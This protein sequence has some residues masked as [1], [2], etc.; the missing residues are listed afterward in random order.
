MTKIP[1]DPNLKSFL[2][3]YYLWNLIL[4]SLFIIGIPFLLL[5]VLGVG[6]WLTG[7]SY[8]NYECFYSDKFILVKKGI[9]FK[10]EKTIP[11]DK[12]QDFTI[13]RGPL[14]NAY[15]LTCIHI[16]TAGQGM[17]YNDSDA[18]LIGIKNPESLEDKILYLKKGI[19]VNEPLRERSETLEILKD[20]NR[21]LHKILESNKKN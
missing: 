5:W 15:G 9:W 18:S 21:T 4:A 11:L 16:E 3:T 20:I 13:R 6:K 10:T 19:V 8:K 7:L 14:L 1:I 2:F 12:I 17:A